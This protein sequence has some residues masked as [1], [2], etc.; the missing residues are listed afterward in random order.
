MRS[1]SPSS[2]SF[3]NLIEKSI[4]STFSDTLGRAKAS[5]SFEDLESKLSNLLEAQNHLAAT[6]TSSTDTASTLKDSMAQLGLDV[7]SRLDSAYKALE[8]RFAIDSSSPLLARI[9]SLES[10]SVTRVS[11]HSHSSSLC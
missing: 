6:L 1:S 11:P 4:R 2:G 3:I 7:T 10:Q 8:E 9:G 5:E